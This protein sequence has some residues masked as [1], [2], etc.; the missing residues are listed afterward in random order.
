MKYIGRRPSRLHVTC[1]LRN[2]NLKFKRVYIALTELI[3]MIVKYYK[4]QVLEVIDQSF[5]LFR[6]LAS[7]L[8]RVGS[9]QG[10]PL[11]WVGLPK[12]EA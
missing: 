12:S 2:V 6:S 11:I 3:A 4:Y 5:C 10:K 8:G 7:D 9:S 1:K